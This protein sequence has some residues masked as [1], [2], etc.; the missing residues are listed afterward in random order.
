[1]K[2]RRE[3]GNSP[4]FC[5]ARLL[6]PRDKGSSLNDNQKQEATRILI[7]H[8]LKNPVFEPQFDKVDIFLKC[9]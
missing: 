8:I 2:D 3:F 7:E 4:V 9:R 5:L 6:D 1:L